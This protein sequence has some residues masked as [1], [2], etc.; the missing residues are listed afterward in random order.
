[1]AKADKA[2]DQRPEEFPVLL[3]EWCAAHSKTDSRV[4]LLGAFHA[5]E[6][7][8]GRVKDLPSAILARFHAFVDAPA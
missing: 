7:A 1:M 6:K 3:E 2:P 4:E 8:A 5:L